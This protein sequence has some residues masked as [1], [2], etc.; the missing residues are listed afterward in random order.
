M[1]IEAN[2]GDGRLMKRAGAT[3][4]QFAWNAT[5]ASSI[6]AN[7]RSA[8]F[9]ARILGQI[10]RRKS[11]SDRPRLR[12]WGDTVVTHGSSTRLHSSIQAIDDV[13]RLRPKDEVAFSGFFRT[14]QSGALFK[15][16]RGTHPAERVSHRW[17]AR[18]R[19]LDARSFY[20]WSARHGRSRLSRGTIFTAI[21]W[22]IICRTTW[23]VYGPF[24]KVLSSTVVTIR[25]DAAPYLALHAD[26]G[27]HLR[28][29]G[30]LRPDTVELKNTDRIDTAYS[31][32]TWST[33]LAPKATL[34]WAPGISGL[35]MGAA[36]WAPSVS[37]S[38]G[39]AFFTEDP[40]VAISGKSAGSAA[41]AAA[42]QSP[43]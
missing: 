18:R 19:A 28:F 6:L 27:K 17:K 3:A 43:F 5:C 7:M 25:H 22:T 26:L 21:I 12:F 41:G 42:L 14:C 13:W 15:L 34:A 8:L 31:F 33:F 36:H 2:Y 37:F 20:A 16:R 9:L 23:L 11:G 4:S 40:R 32:D 29:Y 24:L 39:Q 30:G 35:G 1:A 10:S 38:I